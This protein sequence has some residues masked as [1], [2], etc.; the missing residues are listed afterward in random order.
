[1]V[2]LGLPANSPQRIIES[3]QKTIPAWLDA[4]GLR[5]EKASF[6]SAGGWSRLVRAQLPSAGSW[7][8]LYGNAGNTSSNSDERIKGGL[9]VLWYGDPCPGEIVNRHE[10]AISPLSVNGGLFVQG[11]NN[12]MAYDAYNGRFLCSLENPRA[13]RKGVYNAREPGNMAASDDALFMVVD[14]Q[15]RTLRGCTPPGREVCHS[16]KFH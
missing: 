13:L 4:T 10:G 11:E 1:M 5:T 14:D 6:E 8:H 16:A 9:S 3:A 2:C 7:S 12:V 15:S